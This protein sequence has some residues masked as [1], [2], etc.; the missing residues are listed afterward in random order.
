MYVAVLSALLLVCVSVIAVDRRPAYRQVRGLRRIVMVVL[1]VV[2]T[3]AL[4]NYYGYFYGI[5]LSI[6]AGLV[7]IMAHRAQWFQRH[8]Q[9]LYRRYEKRVG[10]ATQH[11]SWA[12][13]FAT[14]D[15]DESAMIT[16][17][18]ELLDIATR[19]HVLSARELQQFEAILS[20]DHRR[21]KDIMVPV[22]RIVSVS[23]DESLGPIVLDDLHRSGYRQFPVIKA[24]IDH[25]VGVLYLDDIVDL[26]SAKASVRDAYDPRV[27]YVTPRD[28][29]RDVLSRCLESR[30][31]VVIV[32]D[33][34]KTTVGL[35][36]LRDVVA[37][38]LGS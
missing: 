32:Q 4:V 36:T 5:L 19:S 6:V 34:D 12:A 15:V 18:A 8:I 26:R 31:S 10:V 21:V 9:T 14:P 30:R 24:D 38:L 2:T 25:V 17:H 3:T 33:D 7:S 29:V 22:D 16:S 1:F 27:E 20:A 11:W 35:A 37:S 23:V 13:W 28:L